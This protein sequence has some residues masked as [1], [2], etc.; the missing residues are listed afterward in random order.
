MREA[1]KGFFLK[2]LLTVYLTLVG[3]LGGVDP[4]IIQF[5]IDFGLHYHKEG[6]KSIFKMEKVVRG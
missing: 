1:T 2:L 3:A 4:Q 5:Y 6:E